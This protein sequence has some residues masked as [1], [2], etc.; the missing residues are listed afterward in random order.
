MCVEHMCVE[1]VCVEH[2]C[3]ACVWSMWVEHAGLVQPHP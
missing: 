1:H 3:G 2:V